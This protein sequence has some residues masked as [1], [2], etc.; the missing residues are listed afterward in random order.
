MRDGTGAPIRDGSVLAVVVELF[1]D[2]LPTVGERQYLRA[3][4]PIN[5]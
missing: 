1:G 3:S 2:E 5:H 4:S